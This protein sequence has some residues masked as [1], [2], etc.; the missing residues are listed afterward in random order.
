GAYREALAA[1]VGAIGDPA[2]TPSARILAA[3]KR[4]YG[5][6]YTRFVLAHS[7]R[8]DAALR[9]LPL[10][11]AQEA[12]FTRLARESLDEQRQIEAADTL[13]FESF[14]QRYVSPERL[15]V[16]GPSSASA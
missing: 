13:D 16:E 8:H 9:A 12:N 11:A 5:E 14:R 1:A 3:M 10:S 7:A 15:R 2:T 6:S 4:D